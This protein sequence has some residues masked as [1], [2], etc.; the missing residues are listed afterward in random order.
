MQRDIH[1][2]QPEYNEE[3]N[4]SSIFEDEY[5]EMGVGHDGGVQF[6][7]MD[8]AKSALVRIAGN[9]DLSMILSKNRLHMKVDAFMD[10]LFKGKNL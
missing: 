9:S 10:A 8:A 3:F 2:Y 4:Q 1:N 6:S 7:A 5:N